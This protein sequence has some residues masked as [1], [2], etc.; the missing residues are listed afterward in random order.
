MSGCKPT[1]DFRISYFQLSIVVNQSVGLVDRNRRGMSEINIPAVCGSEIE[2]PGVIL[3][4]RRGAA[5]Q[6][7]DMPHMNRGLRLDSTEA[8]LHECNAFDSEVEAEGKGTRLMMP[9][10]AGGSTQEPSACSH[11]HA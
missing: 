8:R 5:L 1:C 9:G 10:H 7:G 6:E 3:R 11:A 2:L 4:P